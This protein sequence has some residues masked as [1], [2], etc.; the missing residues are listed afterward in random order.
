MTQSFGRLLAD[1]FALLRAEADLI[2]RVAAPFLFLP[3]FA[4]Q[5]LTVPPPPLPPPPRDEARLTA[6]M[7]AVA[8]WMQTDGV[9]YI[10]ADAV[11]LFGLL[12]LAF[13]LLDRA[14]PDVGGA[15]RGAGGLYLRA[16]LASVLAAIPVGAGMWLLILPGLYVQARLLPLLP[17]L[18]AERP[19]AAGRAILRSIALTRGIGWPILGAVVTLFLLQWVAVGPLAAMGEVVRGHENP[20]AMT[21]IAA[22][23]AAVQSAY[24][25][26]LLL[27]A[28]PLYRR[29]T[30]RGI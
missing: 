30:S 4:A 10:V 1:G 5:L 8:Q 27:I 17:V 28:V 9:W 25:L 19:V 29:G 20:V 7:E 6:W 16:A 18:V 26:G 23:T 12:S 3:A 24:A 14:R 13:L 22:L 21:L 2:V 11:G 15:M